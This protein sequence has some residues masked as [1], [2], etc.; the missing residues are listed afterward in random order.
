MK[1]LHHK[2][3]KGFTIIELLIVI[4]ILGVLAVALL[5]TINP[6]EAQ[7]KTRDAQRLAHL[8]TLQ[9]LIDQ[10]INDGNAA[11]GAILTANTGVSSTVA[12]AGEKNGQACLGN[13]LG[14]NTCPYGATVP[15]DPNNGVSRTFVTTAA[16]TPPGTGQI[17]AQYRAQITGSDYEVN[18]MQE[19]TANASKISSD[20]GNNNNQWVEV[21]TSLVLLN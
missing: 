15:L 4:A 17:V 12:P 21:G 6:G 9:T 16:A 18:V 2:Y 3:L 11:A 19:S 13:W 14:I 7:K 10:F 8:K 5:I 1:I 20:G